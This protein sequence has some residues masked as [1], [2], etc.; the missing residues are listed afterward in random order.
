MSIKKKNSVHHKNTFAG[1]KD[2]GELSDTLLELFLE[3]TDKDKK[4]L[5]AK[6]ENARFIQCSDRYGKIKLEYCDANY[7]LHTFLINPS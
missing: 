7:T 3:L 1:E 5:R 2:S 4:A 6:I